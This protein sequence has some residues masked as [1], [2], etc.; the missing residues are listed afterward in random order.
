[1]TSW[2]PPTHLTLSV[3]FFLVVVASAVKTKQRYR[4]GDSNR[5]GVV[6]FFVCLFVCVIQNVV[7][8]WLSVKTGI[9]SLWN[10]TWVSSV[11]ADI[12]LFKQP[13]APQPL[14]RIPMGSVTVIEISDKDIELAFLVRVLDGTN[15]HFLAASREERDEWMR[16]IQEMKVNSMGS[17]DVLDSF[18]IDLTVLYWL[19]QAHETSSGKNTKQNKQQTCCFCF[20]FF[21]KCCVAFDD[22]L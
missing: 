7:E 8:G 16:A 17:V 19:P 2:Y 21:F 4:N 18:K 3:F 12:L 6:L 11:G 1:M 22:G 15:F 14:K 10:R 5:A 20:C 13:T 9:W